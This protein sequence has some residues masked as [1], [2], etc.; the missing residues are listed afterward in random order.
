MINIEEPSDDS[1]SNNKS[2]KDKRKESIKNLGKSERIMIKRPAVKITEEDE[3]I[4]DSPQLRNSK[5]T[6]KDA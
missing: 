4:P 5:E 2:K 6:I 3:E 1:K